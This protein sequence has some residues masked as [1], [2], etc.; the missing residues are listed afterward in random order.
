M[1]GGRLI[2]KWLGTEPEQCGSETLYKQTNTHLV[3]IAPDGTEY[4]LRDQR[5]QGVRTYHNCG[6]GDGFRGKI[7]RTIDG[8]SATFIC[9]GQFGDLIGVTDYQGDSQLIDHITGILLLG[10]GTRYKIGPKG[11]VD[12]MQDRNGNQVNF[13]Y[14]S[15]TS[16][17]PNR[18]ADSLNREI[19]F[20]YSVQDGAYGLC[21][22]IIFRGFG[23]A[24]RIIRISYAS[25]STVL[26]SSAELCNGNVCNYQN[27]FPKLDLVGPYNPSTMVSTVWL[28]PDGG[29]NARS[30]QFKYNR[31]GEVARVVL[32]TGGAIEYDYT[33]GYFNSGLLTGTPEGEV[34]GYNDPRLNTSPAPKIG[35][36]RRLKERR[37]YST[38]GT[39]NAYE[40]KTIYGAPVIGP[41]SSWTAET[42]VEVNTYGPLSNPSWLSSSDHHFIG[43]PITQLIDT[44]WGDG[45]ILEGK[46]YK[47]I[48]YQINSSQQRVAHQQVEYSWLGRYVSN[49]PF[50]QGVPTMRA[51][52]TTIL[53]VSPPLVSLRSSCALTNTTCSPI[54]ALGDGFDVYGNQTDVWEYDYGNSAPGA[55]L[56]HTNTN[57]I[58]TSSVNGLRYD[59]VNATNGSPS[60]DFPD[61]EKTVHLRSLPF[62]QEIRNS[63]DAV[64]AATEYKY[65]EYTLTSYSG[66]T[67][68]GWLAPGTAG[69]GNQTTARHWQDYTCPTGPDSCQ[70]TTWG[71]WTGGTW[72]ETHAWYDQ[73]G[74]VKKT[75][76]GRGSETTLEYND[77]FG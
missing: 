68:T 41:H 40:S 14:P 74:N 37:V 75:K 72:I 17:W 24:E 19:L 60:N 43:E 49:G 42:K 12:W 29:G 8:T 54:G 62:R 69:R 61:V 6:D 5:K 1:P 30:Y 44:S 57:F 15:Q 11:R 50:W 63:S 2:I 65:D 38:G 71:N 35:I 31:Y 28:P 18:I 51:T 7:F 48:T 4:E 26:R 67:I 52:K 73:L 34:G 45:N 56:R 32:P 58:T 46:E 36:Y 23:G 10:D 70:Q 25:L 9:D 64:I 22:R 33:G 20:Q 77:R 76:D 47:T 13:F 53:D 3:F 59:T 16:S 66:E 55:L 39:G 27:L 21:D